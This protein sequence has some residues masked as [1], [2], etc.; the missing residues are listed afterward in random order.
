MIICTKKSY[1]C[2]GILIRKKFRQLILKNYLRMLFFEWICFLFA[3]FKYR[4]ANKANKEECQLDLKK[5]VARKW[6]QATI[7]DHLVFS[8]VFNDHP[9]LLEQLLK[10][11]L[12]NFRVRHLN[13]RQ[14]RSWQEEKCRLSRAKIWRLRRRRPGY[15]LWF[16]NAESKP[17]WHWKADSH[18]SS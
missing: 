3:N 9:E 16:G 8:W 2:W 1:L 14:A 10:M 5:A 12:P 15:H 13:Y 6:R 11:W 4:G 7:K 17:A 18:L